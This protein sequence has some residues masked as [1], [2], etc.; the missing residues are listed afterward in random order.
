MIIYPRLFLTALAL[1]FMIAVSGDLFAGPMMMRHGKG[2]G[3]HPHSMGFGE[4]IC[5]RRSVFDDPEHLA[6]GNFFH[7][8][9]AGKVP[10]GGVQARSHHSQSIARHAVTNFAGGGLGIDAKQG[11]P[12]VQILLRGFKR[13]L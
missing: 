6:I 8:F 11:L 1:F 9:S 4:H 3:V 10:W 12:C 2:P 5:S 13:I 7:G